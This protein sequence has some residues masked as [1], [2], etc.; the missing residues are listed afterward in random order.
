MKKPYTPIE[1]PLCVCGRKAVMEKM[2]NTLNANFPSRKHRPFYTTQSEQY[3]IACPELCHQ[4]FAFTKRA[5][6]AK[7]EKE[8]PN[9]RHRIPE[10]ENHD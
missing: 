4:T 2:R 8:V 6:V 10:H 7:F 3:R 5:A 9:Y 1:M